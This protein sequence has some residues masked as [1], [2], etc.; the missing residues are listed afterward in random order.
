MVTLSSDP[1]AVREIILFP[2]SGRQDPVRLVT[3]RWFDPSVIDL[4]S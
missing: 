2:M 1:G 3:E 4:L